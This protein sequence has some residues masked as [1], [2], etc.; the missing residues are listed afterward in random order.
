MPVLSVRGV[1]P[2][3]GHQPDIRATVP[4]STAMN[5]YC[6]SDVYSSERHTL[7]LML[8]PMISVEKS[9][10]LGEETWHL[11]QM[12][13]SQS[14]RTHPEKRLIIVCMT[15]D[16][17]DSRQEAGTSSEGSVYESALLPVVSSLGTRHVWQKRFQLSEKTIP[18]CFTICLCTGISPDLDGNRGT[19]NETLCHGMFL[20]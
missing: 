10:G 9:P 8:S 12:T 5:E 7:S 17:L 15:I 4:T 18:V 11:Y 6:V 20:Y 19:K 13:E 3:E 1:T 16:G 2:C 14:S